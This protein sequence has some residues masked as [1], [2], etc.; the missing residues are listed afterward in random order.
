MSVT[1]AE[2]LFSKGAQQYRHNV[3]QQT[4]DGTGTSSALRKGR[5]FKHFGFT[6]NMTLVSYVPEKSGS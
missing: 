3:L 5:V 4:G 2:E 1:L 6:I